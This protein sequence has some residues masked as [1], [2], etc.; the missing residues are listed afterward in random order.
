M[1]DE[2]S[3]TRLTV[4]RSSFIVQH[5]RA[6]E[7]VPAVHDDDGAVDVGGCV[8][9]EEDGA[10]LD[11]AD[12]AEAAEGNLPAQTF[13][14]RLGDE[15]AH[16]LRVLDG[17][18]RDG[19]DA[20]AVAAPLDREVARQGV[21]ARLR[22]RDVELHRRPE[23]MERRADVENLAAVLLQLLE[24]GAADVEGA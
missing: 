19:V 16:A 1:N 17:A 20:D 10:L 24:G 22:R 6:A 4:H 2:L 11:V 15:A 5:S 12:A 3:T 23:V 14:N 13:F 18:G 7:P 21:H 8:G 9:A